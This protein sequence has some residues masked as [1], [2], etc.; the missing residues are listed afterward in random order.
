MF[1]HTYIL[2]C[3]GVVKVNEVVVMPSKHLRT[4]V[5]PLN[6]FVF[7]TFFHFTAVNRKGNL[8]RT[9]DAGE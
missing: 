2:M 6:T 3:T 9:T 7:R 1:K 4:H 8:K 5:L